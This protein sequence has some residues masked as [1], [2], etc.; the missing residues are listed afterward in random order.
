MK[1]ALTPTTVDRSSLT[2]LNH[3]LAFRW[4]ETGGM[5]GL[6]CLPGDNVSSANAISADGSTIVGYSDSP[7]GQWR[8]V[9]WNEFECR[10]ISDDG[11]RI[12][13]FRIRPPM[14]P[15]YPPS[16]IPYVWDE[17]IGWRGVEQKPSY[18]NRRRRPGSRLACAHSGAGES[19]DAARPR[20]SLLQKIAGHPQVDR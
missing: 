18:S 20:T 12:V 10:A 1:V 3:G 4:T 13:G 9:R 16:Y 8:A 2:P 7:A 14:D 19:D 6:P 17:A 11:S 15:A 5:Q